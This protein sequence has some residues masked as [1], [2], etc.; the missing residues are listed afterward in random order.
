MTLGKVFFWL[1]DF[2]WGTPFIVF[3]LFIGFYFFLR[4]K[5]FTIVH[6]PHIWKHTLV[7]QIHKDKDA[8]QKKA[9]TVSP[10]EA[11]CIAIGGCV[12]AGNIGGVATAIATGGP[13]AV[14][15]LWVW[16]FLGMMIKCV[17][18]TLGCHYRT[19]NEKGEYFGGGT[20]CL[21]RGIGREQHH[22]KLGLF[23]A[24]LLAV[25]FWMQF[26]AGSQAYTISEVL[27]YS[28]GINMVVVTLLYSVMLWYVIWKGVPRIAKLATMAVPFMC[29]AFIIGGLGLIIANIATLP[30]VFVSIFKYAFTPH[31]AVGGFAGCAVSEA[32]SRGLSRSINSGEAGQASSPFIH[33][34][35]DTPH[36][37]A[38][39]LWGAFEIF[40][41]T[42][43]VCSI[44]AL[45]VLCTGEWTSGADGATLSIMAYH[46][47]YGRFADYFIGF[48][49]VLFGI[50]STAG[51]FTYYCTVIQWLFRS[52]PI[53]RDRILFIFKLVFPI[54]NIVIV[55]SITVGGYSADLFWAIVDV[56]LAPVVFSNLLGLF[57][58]RNK[59]FDLLKDY[60][61]RYMGIGKVDPNFR[62]FYEDDPKVFEQEEA[63]RQHFRKIQEDAYA[64]RGKTFK[65]VDEA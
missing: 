33:G 48:I 36:P 19:T 38:E 11:V 65:T 64:K 39:G 3:C 9:G 44:S 45:A 10:I 24:V 2:L 62:V 22:P 32:I 21:E 49:M 31:A 51:W 4:G 23:L 59:F 42:V 18:I 40:M 5:C 34:S 61:A 55:T 57:L 29:V 41:D 8:E 20:Y 37:V 27:H 30:S 43:V 16:A 15:Y 35:A 47:L 60:K 25:C 54:P 46:T 14:F 50:T 1:D 7:A 6:F 53:L 17:E 63:L 58:L 13:G 52:H 12:G 26:L 56:S 28:F